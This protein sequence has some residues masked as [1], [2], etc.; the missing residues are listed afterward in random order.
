MDNTFV[1]PNNTRSEEQ[2]AVYEQ[3]IKDGVCPFCTENFLKYHSKPI[4]KEGAHWIFT[5][6][7]WPY[8]GTKQHFLIVLKRHAERIEDLTAEEGAELITITGEIIKERSVMGGALAM[9]FGKHANLKN[10]VAHIHAQLI[11]PNVDDPNHQ[12]VRLPISKKAD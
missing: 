3:I 2:R 11:E 7:A 4:L 9:R 8:D 1:N 5:E 6:S 12:G 10:S